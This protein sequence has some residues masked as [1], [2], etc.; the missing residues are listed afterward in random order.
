MGC[1]L[2]AL[3]DTFDRAHALTAA[4][5]HVDREFPLVPW[6]FE[7]RTSRARPILKIDGVVRFRDVVAVG[8]C[9]GIP[10]SVY[11]RQT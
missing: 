7:R 2:G 11:H 10:T 3:V 8:P 5:N 1:A 4:P 6:E 9:K